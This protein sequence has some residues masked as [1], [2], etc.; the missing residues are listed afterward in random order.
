MSRHPR[1]LLAGAAA[2]A[3]RGHELAS[4]ALALVALMYNYDHSVKYM[5]SIEWTDL[6]IMLCTECRLLRSIF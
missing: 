6:G 3:V 5:Y 1:S 2:Q 4:G